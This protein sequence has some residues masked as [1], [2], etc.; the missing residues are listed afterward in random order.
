MVR[1]FYQN[2]LQNYF[3][4]LQRAY[5]YRYYVAYNNKYHLNS[6]N[7]TDRSIIFYW[8]DKNELIRKGNQEFLSKNGPTPVAAVWTMEF[9]MQFFQFMNFVRIEKEKLYNVTSTSSNATDVNI[10]VR[11]LSIINSHSVY[12]YHNTFLFLYTLR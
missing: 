3:W 8:Q 7:V 10:K 9:L 2:S 1:Y 11:K 12:I 6:C 5:G 4:L